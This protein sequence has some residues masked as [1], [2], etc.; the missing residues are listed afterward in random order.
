ML[1]AETVH[2]VAHTLGEV[3]FLKVL[4]PALAVGGPA[5]FFWFGVLGVVKKR[6]LLFGRAR[7]AARGQ[8]LVS[9]WVTGWLAVLA[10]V[11]YLVVGLVMLAVMVPLSAA[12]L[13]LW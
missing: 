6:T 1:N 9:G 4:F 2:N 11:I 8:E 12:L 3:P 13:G 7:T 5:V 10:G